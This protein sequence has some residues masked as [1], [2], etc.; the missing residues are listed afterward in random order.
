MSDVRLSA[1]EL[2]AV[3]RL[4]SLFQG[5]MTVGVPLTQSQILALDYLTTALPRMVVL[6]SIDKQYIQ[7]LRN[8]IEVWST[9][10]G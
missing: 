1:E 2:G 6:S 4:L 7:Q 8:K 9:D 3:S 10:P 5:T